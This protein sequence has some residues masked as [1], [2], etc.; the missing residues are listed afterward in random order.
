MKCIFKLSSAVLFSIMYFNAHAM[1]PVIDAAAITQLVNEL[2]QLQQQTTLIKIELTQ[3]SNG[4]YQWS[5]AQGLINN[6]AG[7]INKTNTLSYSAANIDQQFRAAYPGYQAPRNFSQEYQN[8]TNMSLNTLNGILQSV[9]ASANDFTNENAR[10]S[11]LQ[12]QAQSS[13]GELQAIQAS[14]QIASEEVSQMQLLRQI[15]AAQTN[16]QTVYY[17]TQLQKE[18]SAHA[19]LSQVIAAGSTYMPPYGSSGEPLNPPF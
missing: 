3:L 9:G 7:I 2:E 16:A 1:M 12:Q 10:L 8:N 5:N 4:Q 19:E 14:S 11:F 17:S 18:A 15:M 13:K 6:L